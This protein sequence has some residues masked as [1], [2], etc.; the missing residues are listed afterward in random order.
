MVAEKGAS[1]VIIRWLPLA[2]AG[3]FYAVRYDALDATVF[4]VRF[5][6]R[7][8]AD[9]MQNVDLSAHTVKENHW[10]GRTAKPTR[11]VWAGS[12]WRQKTDVPHY[13]EKTGG[14]GGFIT[15]K[16]MIPQY[17]IGAFCM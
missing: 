16:A 7:S 15:Y 13:P 4:V 1:P 14:G 5:H 10:D 12:I 9:R 8:H 3:L 17:N 2:A 6:H 11:S